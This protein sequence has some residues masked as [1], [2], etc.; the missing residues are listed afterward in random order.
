MENEK[1]PK[2]KKEVDIIALA[3]KCNQGGIIAF[4]K[5]KEFFRKIVL[6]S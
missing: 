1:L 5:E 2:K 4:G 3:Q 6:L